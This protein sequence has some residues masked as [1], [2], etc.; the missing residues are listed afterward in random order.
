MVKHPCLA[1]GPGVLVALVW[2]CGIDRAADRGSIPVN[3]KIATEPERIPIN[4]YVYASCEKMSST[5]NLP[6]RLIPASMAA[7]ESIF[8]NWRCCPTTGIA[9]F[10]AENPTSMKIF[11]Q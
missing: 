9:A 6:I 7:A 4:P 10:P 11:N 5:E 3:F 1:T 8:W 2:M